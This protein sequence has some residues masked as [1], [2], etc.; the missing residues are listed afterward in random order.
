VYHESLSEIPA[1]LIAHTAMITGIF[2]EGKKDERDSLENFF[3][4]YF[5]DEQRPQLAE[6]CFLFAR[7]PF[8]LKLNK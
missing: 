4:F 3:L 5:S 2:L 8:M 7:L 1:L 6:F